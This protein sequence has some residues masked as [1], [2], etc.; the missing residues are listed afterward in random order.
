MA[1][2]AA[3]A[4]GR[5]SRVAS[6]ARSLGS[7]A[8]APPLDLALNTPKEPPPRPFLK[9]V[10]GKR[11]LLPELLEA[12]DAARPFR[13]YHEPFL[14][15]GA[16]FFALAR[17][18][19]LEPPSCLSDVNHNL[20]DAYLGVR[21]EID[22]VIHRLREHKRRHDEAHF[23]AVRA[24]APRS[25]AGRAARVIYLN[26][27]CYNGL[28]RENSKGGFNTPF[29][30]YKNPNI[31]DEEN[32]RAVAA[33]LRGVDIAARGF[34]CVLELARRG[35]L[36]YLDPPYHPLSKTASFTS[37]S[38]DGFDVDA[39]RRLAEVFAQLAGRGVKVI[40]SNSMT[41][42]T[43]QLYGGHH[44]YEVHAYRS[45]NSRTDRRGPVLEAL[46]TSFPIPAGSRAREQPPAAARGGPGATARP[47]PP[48]AAAPARPRRR[49]SPAAPVQPRARVDGVF[50][51]TD[52][53][54]WLLRNG[55]GDVA[56]L[57]DRV[58]ALWLA[59]GKRTR[60]N[61]WE[62]LAGDRLGRSRRVAGQE[63]PVLRA[64]QR[65]QG[66]PVTGNAL[67]RNPGEEAPPIRVVT[68][69]GEEPPRRGVTRRKRATR[70][71]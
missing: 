18:G 57:I 2:A 60:R 3:P 50:E 52:A 11:Q 36:V 20:I 35:D 56:A 63:F 16:L 31:C 54:Q 22:S 48:V 33:T 67:A 46:V 43:W 69:R 17:G 71:G 47:A 61:W 38:R 5:R 13:H 25:L 68:Q 58:T 44:V 53:R 10:G 27:T 4:T 8:N 21:N 28:Y 40:L 42:L 19:P 30:R 7:A 45:V 49:V 62:I 34:E 9:W 14:G 6:M 55:Y 26:K 39:Q 29:G 65:R 15:G 64:A 12:V 37:Y 32:L 23:Y 1:W 70:G 41:A 59:S 51:R 24:S 66:V